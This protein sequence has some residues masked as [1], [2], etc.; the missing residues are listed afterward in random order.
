[1]TLN[2]TLNEL[3]GP[4]SWLLAAFIGWFVSLDVRGLLL[5]HQKD[6]K[7]SD[8]D[9][10][11]KAI[12]TSVLHAATHAGLFYIYIYVI[13][14]AISIPPSLLIWLNAIFPVDPTESA[15][16]LTY[17]V[18]AFTLGLLWYTYYGKILDNYS[19]FVDDPESS[20]ATKRIDVRILYRLS[21]KVLRR[22]NPAAHIN[23]IDSITSPLQFLKPNTWIRLL[24]YT[25]SRAG[26]SFLSFLFALMVAIDM[27]AVSSLIRVFFPGTRD[28]ANPT[29]A[30]KELLFHF[31]FYFAATVGKETEV[32][33]GIIFFSVLFWAFRAIERNSRLQ[34]SVEQR[35][36]KLL[37]L[38]LREPWCMFAV[39]CLAIGH[40]FGLP[41]SNGSSLILFYLIMPVAL[42]WLLT[43]L[44]IRSVG[45]ENIRKNVNKGIELSLLDRGSG[46]IE[47]PTLR[48]SV[49]KFL[50]YAGATIV[51]LALALLFTQRPPISS[52]EGLSK[53]FFL[54]S[55]LMAL[56]GVILLYF[57]QPAAESKINAKID[58][59]YHFLGG[60]STPPKDIISLS[61]TPGVASPEKLTARFYLLF[62]MLV[63]L[64]YIN[65]RMANS[66]VYF[67]LPFIRP[68][69]IE[70]LEWLWVLCAITLFFIYLRDKREK[71]ETPTQHF[72]LD[73]GETLG[74][75]GLSVALIS[76]V[77][78][79][80][81]KPNTDQVIPCPS[82]GTVIDS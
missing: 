58:Y 38:R 43:Q 20:I 42:G 2:T 5:S 36:E 78:I 39:L 56:A 9:F 66:L 35:K 49:C 23:Y 10:W 55:T 46:T 52:G 71:R 74:A 53:L 75:I 30:G 16:T 14:A 12:W 8:P 11:H 25:I 51:G 61:S 44:L 32:F 26:L 48:I 31:D 21:T 41:P 82:D 60:N 73:L 65:L 27:L 54:I 72:R 24:R 4:V 47:D 69:A 57:L 17:I 28:A 64:L 70:M 80:F 50:A 34:E 59:V 62:S 29:G 67:T 37:K 18:T 22:Y 63:L 15:R 33:A 81:P 76:L 45:L 79:A 40:L 6:F 7:R 68:P 1:M 3:I 77:L 13:T 19:D